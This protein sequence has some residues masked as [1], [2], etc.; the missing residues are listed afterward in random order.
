MTT[1]VDEHRIRFGV[2]PIFAE[3][4][5]APS[6][7]YE[8]KRREREPDRRSARCNGIVNC[9]SRFGGC[10]S[11]ISGCTGHA[12]YGANYSEKALG[13]RAALWSV[14]CDWRA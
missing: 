8:H 2:E 11:P 13:W 10:G 5:I 12:R 9:A 6:T 3:L 14:S 7:Y 1:F 4:P